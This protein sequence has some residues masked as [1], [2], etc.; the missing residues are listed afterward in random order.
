M[1]NGSLVECIQTPPMDFLLLILTAVAKMEIPQKGE[2]YVIEGVIRCSC[3]KHD[4]FFLVEI[5]DVAWDEKYFKELQPPVNMEEFLREPEP[6]L[7]P[8]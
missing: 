2:T 4:K 7:M 3:G 8:A 6:E 1:Q 5:P